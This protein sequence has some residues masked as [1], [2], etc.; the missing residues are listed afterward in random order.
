MKCSGVGRRVVLSNPVSLSNV[1]ERVKRHL[2]LPSVRLA[3]GNGCEDTTI[4]NTIAI[5]AGSG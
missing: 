3:R 2:Q 5:C 1:V 4:V